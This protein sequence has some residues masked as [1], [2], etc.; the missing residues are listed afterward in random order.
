MLRFIRYLL[1]HPARVSFVWYAAAV[2]IG[3]SLLSMPVCQNPS[4]KP[5]GPVD[6]TFTA[7]SAVCVTG[8]TVVSTG[9][10]LSWMGQIVVLVL[11]QLGGIGIISV[12]T[13]VTLSMGARQGLRQRSLLADT[14]GAGEEPDLKWVLS[15]VIR[16]TLLFEASGAILLTIR[17]LFNHAPGE[18]VWH[19][20]FHSISA[21]CNA[22]FSLNDDSLTR[23]QGDPFVNV[24]IMVLV[25]VGG[26]ERVVFPEIEMAQNLAD[27]MTWPNVLDYVPID[28]DY[29]VVEFT[30]PPSLAGK[31]LLEADLRRSFH[32]WII[33]IKD[34]LTGKLRMFPD[35]EF[36]FTDDQLLVAIGKQDDLNRFRE[37][38]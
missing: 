18:A 20:V 8:L 27:R 33:A 26:I 14:L 31:T 38:D 21:F 9:N 30:V 15:H 11:I 4:T 1:D 22:G 7:T 35:P 37:V 28:P 34:A 6:A 17:F 12:T 13:F 36:R 2:V 5:L 25:I 19:A 3:G 24:T 32:I 23:Y 16:F 10:D 29:S